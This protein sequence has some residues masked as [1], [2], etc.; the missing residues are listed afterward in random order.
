[1]KNRA[2][3]FLVSSAVSRAVGFLALWLVLAGADP[4]DLPAGILAIVAASWTSLRLLPPGRSQSSPVAL[5][6]LA[7][8]FF[9][10]SAIAGVDVAWRALDPRLPL[11]SGF[12]VYPPRLAPSPALN[13]FCTLTSV[14]PGTLAAGPDDSGAVVVHCLDV[15]Q[16]VVAHLAAD[17]ALFVKALGGGHDDV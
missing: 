12:V 10:Q 11:R 15:N 2:G 8:R 14:A 16:S 17:E 4:A 6:S 13:A 1:M 7:L 5:T 3:G 9:W